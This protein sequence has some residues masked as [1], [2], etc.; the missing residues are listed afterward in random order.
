M[1]A[2]LYLFILSVFIFLPQ[3]SWATDINV[4]CST[5]DL[6]AAMDSAASGDNIIIAAGT[7]SGVF[8]VPSAINTIEGAGVGQT[9]IN[10]TDPNTAAVTVS[11]VNYLRIR[12]LTIT[13]GNSGVLALYNN[14]LRLEECEIANV[15]GTGVN[16]TAR[17]AARIR[18]CNIH[19]N[20]TGVAARRGSFV[21]IRDLS[22][23]ATTI[24]DNSNN[25]VSVADGSSANIRE[26]TVINNNSPQGISVDNGSSVRVMENASITQNDRNGIVIANNSSARVTDNVAITNNG[27]TGIF[28]NHGSS[29]SLEGATVTGNNTLNFLVSG[30]VVAAQGSAVDVVSS[31]VSNN[32]RSGVGLLRNSTGFLQGSTLSNNTGQGVIAI[33]DSVIR[34]NDGNFIQNNGQFGVLC[35]DTSSKSGTIPDGNVTGNGAGQINCP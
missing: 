13:G 35:V 24:H 2:F 33:N 3:G 9:I 12:R 16:L 21:E 4:D 32:T 26:N 25:G 1:Q 5:D 14:Q 30:G 8:D 28:L 19:D 17:S 11:F 27:T 6:Q 34:F 15:P 31:N 22:G 18:D 23:N 7:C 20:S 10:G 29:A